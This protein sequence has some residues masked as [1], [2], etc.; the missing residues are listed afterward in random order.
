VKISEFHSKPSEIKL[1]IKYFRRGNI[2]ELLRQHELNVTRLVREANIEFLKPS[3]EIFLFV[4]LSFRNSLAYPQAIEAYAQYSPTY[5]QFKKVFS[6]FPIKIH[7]HCAQVFG[8]KNFAGKSKPQNAV[9]RVLKGRQMV[10]LPAKTRCSAGLP[11]M[12]QRPDTLKCSSSGLIV[13]F[14][15]RFSGWMRRTLLWWRG[16]GTIGYRSRLVGVGGWRM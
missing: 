6:P 16:F 10:D 13:W 7:T 11:D 4:S 1:L 8:R 14:I 5:P 15:I 9:W 3:D 12:I 2:N